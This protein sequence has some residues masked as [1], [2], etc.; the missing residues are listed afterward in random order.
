MKGCVKMNYLKK[1]KRGLEL[2]NECLELFKEYAIFMDRYFENDERIKE[3]YELYLAYE[4]LTNNMKMKAK[5]K[6]FIE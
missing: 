6:G 1:F 3:H 5:Q 4:N 2:S